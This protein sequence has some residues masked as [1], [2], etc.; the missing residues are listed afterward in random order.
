MDLLR[1]FF[2]IHKRL[3]IHDIY[4]VVVILFWSYFTEDMF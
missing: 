4:Q 1:V 3:S 2:S